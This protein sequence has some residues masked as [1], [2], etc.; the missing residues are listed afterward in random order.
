MSGYE[1]KVSVTAVCPCCGEELPSSAYTT[2]ARPSEGVF[3]RD[4][5]WERTDRR[6]SITTCATCFVPRAAVAELIEKVDE[7]LSSHGVYSTYGGSGES[8]EKGMHSELTA[9]LSRVRGAE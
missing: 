8:I 1:I 3:D 5:P 7:L 4:N 6:V 2:I 9:T